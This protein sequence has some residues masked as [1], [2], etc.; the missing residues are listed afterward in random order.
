MTSATRAVTRLTDATIREQ[1]RVR[2]VVVT[3][4]AIGVKVRL[5]GLKRSYTVTADAI[6]FFAARM[7]AERIR[8]ERHKAKRKS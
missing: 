1:G 3:I 2:E 8:A 7:E 5:K 4:N 6:Y